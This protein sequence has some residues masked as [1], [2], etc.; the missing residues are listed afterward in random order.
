LEYLKRN[1]GVCWSVATLRRVVAAGCNR[2]YA[3]DFSRFL[4]F[5]GADLA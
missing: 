4:T 1:H 3:R 2:P 5:F